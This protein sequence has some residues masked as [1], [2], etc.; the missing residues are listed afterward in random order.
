M[1]DFRGVVESLVAV[2]GE[3]AIR[4]GKHLLALAVLFAVHVTNVQLLNRLRVTDNAGTAALVASVLDD[5]VRFWAVKG[6]LGARH[7]GTVE[8]AVVVAVARGTTVH[9]DIQL[10]AIGVGLVS[11]MTLGAVLL[12]NFIA[13]VLDRTALFNVIGGVLSRLT[14]TD[15][16]VV[17][18]QPTLCQITFCSG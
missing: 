4:L 12:C 15:F 1:R 17:L 7:L 11:E 14:G 6:R 18:G 13:I 9:V 8:L 3:A 2:A 10:L 5:A 16:T